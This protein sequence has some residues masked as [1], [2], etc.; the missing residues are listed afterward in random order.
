M[1]VHAAAPAKAPR[2]VY[3]WA[4]GTRSVYASITPSAV[5]DAP[6]V[7]ITEWQIQRLNGSAAG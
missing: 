3:D 2:V 5:Q 1:A 7:G 4:S 6:L